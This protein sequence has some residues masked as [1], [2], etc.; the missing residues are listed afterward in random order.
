M[1]S[2]TRKRHTT[3]RITNSHPL[4]KTKDGDRLPRT[5]VPTMSHRSSDLP[6]SDQT[7]EADRLAGEMAPHQINSKAEM[8]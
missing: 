7:L 8:D 5:S 3:S 4:H 1:T 6:N 2:T